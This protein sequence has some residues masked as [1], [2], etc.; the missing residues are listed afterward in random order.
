MAHPLRPGETLLDVSVQGETWINSIVNLPQAPMVY[1]ETGLWI[2][3]MSALP[4]WFTDIFVEDVGD[5]VRKGGSEY[6]RGAAIAR[7]DETDE[8]YQNIGMDERSRPWAGEL[9]DGAT[10]STAYVPYVSH[11]TLRVARDWYGLAS[12]IDYD[13]ASFDNDPPFVAQ[14]V[15]GARLSSLATDAHVTQDPDPSATLSMWQMLDALFISTTVE[16]TYAEYLAANGVDPRRVEGMSRPVALDHTFFKAQE[17]PQII[18]GDRNDTVVDTEQQH[19]ASTWAGAQWDSVTTDT[20]DGHIWDMRP[21]GSLSANIGMRRRRNIFIEEPSI[22]L[23]TFVY[24]VNDFADAGQSSN[25]ITYLSH[26]GHWGDRS[27]GDADEEDFMDVRQFGNR[28]GSLAGGGPGYQ[29]LLHLYLH[30]D[31]FFHHG[32]GSGATVD[33]LAFREPGGSVYTDYNAS[34]T[35]KMSCQLAIASDLV[36][37]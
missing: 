32:P 28:D 34:V 18:Q 27:F 25:D 37:G 23:G 10:D 26:A 33:T 12:A 17:Q 6:L 5:I 19:P 15:E 7:D 35:A 2:I 1:G 4:P 30:G 29:N 13:D 21:F 14:Y 9:G 20:D 24:Y 36:G 22:L 16:R 11:S 31:S 3:P 8:G